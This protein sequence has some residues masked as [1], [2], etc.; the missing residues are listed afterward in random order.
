MKLLALET[1]TENCSVALLNEDTITF[2]SEL[3]P[4]HHAEIIIPM[5]D[6]PLKDSSL[7]NNAFDGIC[8]IQ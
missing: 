1:S 3:T 4:H 5:L 7:T 8:L 2:K 6:A